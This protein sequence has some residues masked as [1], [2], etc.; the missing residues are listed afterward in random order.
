MQRLWNEKK[1]GYSVYAC[2]IVGHCA[3]A[4]CPTLAYIADP[5]KI[6]VVPS[7]TKDIIAHRGF[8]AMHINYPMV[9]REP[10]N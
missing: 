9:T 10:L 3:T 5:G 2:S 6:S 1:N 8:A 4:R 7:R